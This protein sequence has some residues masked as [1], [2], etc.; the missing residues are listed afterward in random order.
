MRI[1]GPGGN[2]RVS[3]TRVGCG[4]AGLVLLLLGR[5]RRRRWGRLGR[6]GGRGLGR[7]RGWERAGRA[8]IRRGG[9]DTRPEMTGSDGDHCERGMEYVQVGFP[10]L[11]GVI[12]HGLATY[13]RRGL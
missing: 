4:R 5:R 7:R 12:S 9:S 1:V 8:L 11:W 3:R 13:N 2:G 6:R 10:A